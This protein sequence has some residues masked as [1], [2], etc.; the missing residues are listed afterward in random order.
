MNRMKKAIVSIFCAATTLFCCG[1]AELATLFSPVTSSGGAVSA[2]TS[3][4][5]TTPSPIESSAAGEIFEGEY[6]EANAEQIQA[7]AERFD[8]QKGIWEQLMQNNNGGLLYQVCQDINI[9]GGAHL[10]GTDEDV[11]INNMN[12]TAHFLQQEQKFGYEVDIMYGYGEK[13]IVIDTEYCNGSEVYTKRECKGQ[14]T[15]TVEAFSRE[16]F[17]MEFTDWVDD[18]AE[19][20]SEATS[21]N[22]AEFQLDEADGYTRLLIKWT[23]WLPDGYS[24]SEFEAHFIYNGEDKLI[25]VSYKQDMGIASVDASFEPWSGNITP[26]SDLDT[27]VSV[28][29]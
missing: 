28:R 22:E 20:L 29:E 8:T 12:A 4:T 25:A 17:F 6:K 3:T 23:G 18:L 21:N 26:P 5:S 13:T 10:E 7:F 19:S 27:Y 9:V 16:E 11:M 2:P 24:E 15:K 14:T 1:C